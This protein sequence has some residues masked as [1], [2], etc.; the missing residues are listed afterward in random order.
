MLVSTSLI[1]VLSAVVATRGCVVGGAGG[2]RGG[3]LSLVVVARLGLVAASLFV[4]GD[5]A[6][7]VDTIRI[8]VIGCGGGGGGS[9]RR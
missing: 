9:G 8:A 6:R 2:I 1:L 4:C 5:S 7:R 3:F